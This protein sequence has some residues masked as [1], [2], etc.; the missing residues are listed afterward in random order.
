MG[1]HI[2][3]RSMLPSEC[4]SPD[5]VLCRAS[6]CCSS[7]EIHSVLPKEWRHCLHN[8]LVGHGYRLLFIQSQTEAWA[9][10]TVCFMQNTRGNYEILG[11]LNKAKSQIRMTLKASRNLSL[12]LLPVQTQAPT[13]CANS[14]YRLL[15][16]T[17]QL[18]TWLSFQ[19]CL[20]SQ[21][22]CLS[23]T[24]PEKSLCSYKYENRLQ[25]SLNEFLKA[26]HNCSILV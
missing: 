4:D 5:C 7:G 14:E 12:H 25:L 24:F 8:Y 10:S 6:W 9:D 1:W 11:Y 23:A 20:F 2:K 3:T 13:Q 22:G 19:T 16:F 15:L 17:Y 18:F 26:V 21:T